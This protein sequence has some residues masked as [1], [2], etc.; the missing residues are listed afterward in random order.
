MKLF[1]RLLLLA[2]LNYLSAEPDVVEFVG[3]LNVQRPAGR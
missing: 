1:L 3:N 2:D